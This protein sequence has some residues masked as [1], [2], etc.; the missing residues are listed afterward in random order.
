[1]SSETAKIVR[2]HKPG[3]PE[4]LQLDELPPPRARTK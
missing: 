3:A 4:V 2:F 1:M